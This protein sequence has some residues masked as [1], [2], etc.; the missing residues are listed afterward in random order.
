MHAEDA[1]RIGFSRLTLEHTEVRILFHSSFRLESLT[2]EFNAKP[3]D[4]RRL[5]PATT[6]WTGQ[7]KA[8]RARLRFHMTCN[9]THSASKAS[10]AFVVSC[11]SLSSGAKPRCSIRVRNRDR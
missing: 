10:Q 3:C 7:Q 6:G 1:L 4:L 8:S 9:A 5:R 2:Y 11:K